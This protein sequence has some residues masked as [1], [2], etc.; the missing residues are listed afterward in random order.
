MTLV[1]TR[2]PYYWEED[3]K[4]LDKEKI[5]YLYLPCLEYKILK[6]KFSFPLVSPSKSKI[7]LTSF[8]AAKI[9]VNNSQFKRALKNSQIFVMGK[10]TFDFLNKQDLN[11]HWV[12]SSSASELAQKILEQSSSGD[13]FIL[14]GPLERAF[15]MDVFFKEKGYDV[16]KIDCYQTVKKVRTSAFE[17]LDKGYQKKIAYDSNFVV[18]FG[19]P[20]A[21]Q[22]FLS[23]FSLYL[24]ELR[25]N[26]SVIVL[27]ETTKKVCATSFKEVFLTEEPKLENIIKIY[28]SLS[29]NSNFS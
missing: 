5:N 1:W 7:I 15:P 13:F 10:K 20:S 23:E 18:S 6:K 27:G 24:K 26:I 14:P 19:S 22:A 16:C 8:L 17:I 21:V 25:K 3:K 11:V 4:N 12:K 9:I 28:Q 2:S 29:S